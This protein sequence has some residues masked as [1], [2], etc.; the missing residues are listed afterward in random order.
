MHVYK[1]GLLKQ[2][3]YCL[4]GHDLFFA[5]KWVMKKN[6]S[7]KNL[8]TPFKEKVIFPGVGITLKEIKD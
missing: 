3:R 7:E 4:S 2:E 1:V 5:I 8:I 6:C